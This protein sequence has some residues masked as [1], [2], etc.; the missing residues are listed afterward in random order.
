MSESVQPFYNPR[1]FS[2]KMLFRALF[3]LLAFLFASGAIA[4]DYPYMGVCPKG[5]NVFDGVDYFNKVYD[6]NGAYLPNDSYWVSIYKFAQ[7]NCT[8]YVAYWLNSF[9]D[10]HS[11]TNPMFTNSYY[12]YAWHD[13][14]N[15][16]GALTASV[17]VPGYFSR[18]PVA[19]FNQEDWVFKLA[20]D[21]YTSYN[22]TMAIAW[23]NA[24]ATN[25]SGH[26]ARTKKVFSDGTT[27]T[28]AEFNWPSASN[29]Y[30][31]HSYGERTLAKTDSGYPDGFLY[32][33]TE[34]FLECDLMGNICTASG[35]AGGSG[36]DSG[37]A[38]LP[39]P[40]G[41]RTNLV[42]HVN[43][44]L[45]TGDQHQISADCHTCSTE[46]VTEGQNVRVE[47]QTETKDADAKPWLRKAFNSV[48][49]TTW[50]RI[51]E[52]NGGGITPWAILFDRKFDVDVLKK[53]KTYGESTNFIIPNFGGKVLTIATCADSTDRVLESGE[54]ARRD[55]AN[56]PDECRTDNVS[57]KE[58][59]SINVKPRNVDYLIQG[60]GMMNAPSYIQTGKPFTVWYEA[61]NQGTETPVDYIAVSVN[62]INPRGMKTL[63][64]TRYLGPTDLLPKTVYLDQPT[65]SFVAP[66]VPGVYQLEFCINTEWRSET[67]T[68]NDCFLYQKEIRDPNISLTNGAFRC[69]VI[70]PATWGPP[71]STQ[72]YAPPFKSD[73]TML[74]TLWC[75]VT[76][77][78]Y[79]EV[80]VRGAADRLVYPRMY[81]MNQV[82]GAQVEFVSN[83]CSEPMWNGWCPGVANL[84]ISGVGIDTSVTSKP[85]LILAYICQSIGT[86]WDCKWTQQAATISARQ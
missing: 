37:G 28:F 14:Y 23:W 50:W 83:I 68:G 42:P 27:A 79:V 58:R 38:D 41:T 85:T 12:H 3:F 34:S 6:K 9:L 16:K 26:V 75:V 25:K 18:Y 67:N 24:T 30:K 77:P 19:P 78:N 22:T 61:V 49:S 46:P 60:G 71:W 15:W 40:S 81:V 76:Q 2:M 11:P 43:V 35:T 4:S 53:G 80:F 66:S 1:K 5:G 48:V 65:D 82:T 55:P 57:R 45:T 39:P 59:F 10:Q 74:I 47:Q 73:G 86:S 54:S 44:Y 33:V 62:L 64:T 69:P 13:A 70:T 32:I 29:G 17:P 84:F 8:D 72:Q 52:K 51:E 7:C 56:S 21:G 20:P 31:D 36:G 63:L